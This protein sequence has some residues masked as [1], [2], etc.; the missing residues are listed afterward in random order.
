MRGFP[1]F[2]LTLSRERVYIVLKKKKKTKTRR[3]L[4]KIIVGE[5]NKHTEILERKARE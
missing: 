2:H 1:L 5:N 3:K 4:E